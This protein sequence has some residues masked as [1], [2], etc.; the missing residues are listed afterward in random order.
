[1]QLKQE[2]IHVDTI[3]FSMAD[4]LKKIGNASTLDI[5]F[6]PAINEWN[7]TRN[8]QLTLKAIRPGS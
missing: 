8:L 6:A 4:Q 2:R 1:M 7:G 3:G 5:T